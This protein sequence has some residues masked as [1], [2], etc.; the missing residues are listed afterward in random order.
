MIQFRKENKE[1]AWMSNFYPCPI[2]IT[3][4]EHEL[5]FPTSEHLYQWSKFY[6]SNPDLAEK[7]RTCN[8]PSEARKLGQ[9]EKL[10]I[11]HWNNV[12]VRVMKRVLELKLEQHP[13][14]KLKLINT[15]SETIEE[16]APWD[17]FWGTGKRDSGQNQLG[18]LWMELR[19]ELT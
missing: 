6:L 16:Y 13:E 17:E 9:T 19:E 10:N 14:L 18:K 3:H 11:K 5:E 12:R 1:F 8:K 2:K 4:Y 15:G 7:I